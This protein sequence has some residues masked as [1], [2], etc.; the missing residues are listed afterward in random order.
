MNTD[1]NTQ[2]DL[3]NQPGKELNR[4][5]IRVPPF[6][7]EKPKLWFC[8]LE[9]QFNLNGI[10]RDSTK[11]W[12]VVSQLDN[13][14]V[15]EIEDIIT[16]PPDTDKYEK[17]KTELINRLSCSQQQRIKQL[18]EHEEM[19]D[20]TP[21]QFLR[22]LKNLA[23]NTVQDEF[24]RTLWL[25]R[26]PAVMQAILAAQADLTLTK[27]AEIADKIKESTS[28]S[29]PQVASVAA[30]EEL[31]SLKEQVKQ[32]SLQIGELSRA[33]S[34]DRKPSRNSSGSRGPSF[35]RRRTDASVGDSGTCWY[36]RRYGARARKCKAPCN[37]QSEN[38]SHRHY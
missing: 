5:G 14:Y 33:R 18:L 25:N 11:F 15:Q 28:S 10:T 6:W 27:V 2:T 37:Y 34:R 13:R 31:E 3:A 32:L 4:I 38:E 16:T 1:G 19:G 35:S 24:L 26:L 17:V 30:S 8:Q 23:G 20:R 29:Q 12:Y 21:S 22:H 9:C 7:P 36:H